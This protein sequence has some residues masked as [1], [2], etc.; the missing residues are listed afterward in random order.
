MLSLLV[1]IFVIITLLWLIKIF[2]INGI[3]VDSHL[4]QSSDMTNKI[5]VVTGVSVGA[6]GF[7]VAKQLAKLGATVV[8]IVYN[9]Q[10]GNDAVSQI[11]DEL[12]QANVEYIVADLSELEQVRQVA[13]KIKNQYDRCD[14]LVNCAAT[15]MCPH[16]LTRDGIEMQFGV[17]YLSHFL[18]TILLQDLVMKCQGRV[19]NFSSNAFKYLNQNDEF[20]SF[21]EESVRNDGRDI[22]SPFSLYA[23]SKLA[24]QLSSKHLSHHI[25]KPLNIYS[26]HPGATRSTYV[27]P[28]I[29]NRP[30]LHKYLYTPL[31]YYFM[32]SPFQGIQTCLHLILS[33]LEVLENGEFYVD[34]QVE[35]I[36]Q[37]SALTKQIQCQLYESSMSLCANYLN[38][39]T[40]V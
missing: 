38:A 2:I 16:A 18:L 7:E 15:I 25:H 20:C 35:K 34:C 32:K 23:R 3:Y 37:D 4:L 21:T 27:F 17:N 31:S 36:V 39:T 13:F 29:K 28:F 19:I 30:F 26:L 12:G 24:I 11:K 40:E 8:L 1:T 9:M 22:A 33:P 10:I 14:V 5:C 6:L